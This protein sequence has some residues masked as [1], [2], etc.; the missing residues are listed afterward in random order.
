MKI[1][2]K[3][4]FIDALSQDQFDAGLIKFNIP[5]ENNIHSENGEGVWGWVT[6]EDKEKY[7]NDDF[8]GKIPAILL[9]APLNYCGILH[10]WDEV[11][12]QCHG[13]GRPTLDPDWVKTH[14]Q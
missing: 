13:T 4:A 8:Y 14:L 5:A 2:N 6:P 12:L 7:Q 1:E 9:N 10:C 11:V 3:I